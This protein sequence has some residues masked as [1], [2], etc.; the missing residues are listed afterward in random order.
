NRPDIV[1]PALLRPGR[2]DRLIYIQM[3]DKEAR[4]NIFAVHLRGKPLGEDVDIE[5]LAK[6][7]DR[8]VGADIAAIVKEAV[9]AALREFIASGI[10]GEHMKEAVK[11]V[12]IKKKHFE[13]ALKSV[14]PTTTPKALQ[15][16]EEKTEDLVKHAYA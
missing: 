16:F 2:L 15:E 6:W 9:M 13:A 7:T 14:K 8:Y 12:V 10:P 5:E 1:D 4:K 11:N 3:P